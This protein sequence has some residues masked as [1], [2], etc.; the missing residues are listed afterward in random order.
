VRRQVALT[1]GYALVE[2]TTVVDGDPSAAD[3]TRRDQIRMQIER[4]RTNAEIE[5]LIAA[6][7]ADTRIVVAEDRM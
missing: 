7:R 6:L 5:G 2:L 3:T 4:S 1:D